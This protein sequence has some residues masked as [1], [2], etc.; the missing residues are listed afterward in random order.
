ML[1]KNP[2]SGRADRKPAQPGHENA[3]ERQRLDDLL[4][5]GLRETFPAS[6]PV[7]IAQP[8]AMRPTRTRQPRS[9]LRRDRDR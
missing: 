2:Q 9:Q 7:A 6:D 5:E 4:D 8:S 3:I 1:N